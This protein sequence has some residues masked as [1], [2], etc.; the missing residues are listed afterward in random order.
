MNEAFS[1][2][3]FSTWRRRENMWQIENDI[4]DRQR[5]KSFY[6]N[7]WLKIDK[8]IKLRTFLSRIY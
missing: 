6:W 1:T 4:S 3:R 8:C 7:T 2:R 5:F